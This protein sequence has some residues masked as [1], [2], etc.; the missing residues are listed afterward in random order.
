MEYFHLARTDFERV[1]EQKI[2]ARELDTDA[3][4]QITT[5][6]VRRFRSAAL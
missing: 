3:N 1:V 4:I 6:D 5:R 2:V